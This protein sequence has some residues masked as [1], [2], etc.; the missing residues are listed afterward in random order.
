MPIQKSSFS[1]GGNSLSE[2]LFQWA[3]QRRAEQSAKRANKAYEMGLEKGGSDELEQEQPIL[4]FIGSDV[5]EAHNKGL[6]DAYIAGVDSDNVQRVNQIALE[7]ALPDCRK[8]L[9]SL[10]LFTLFPIS[11]PWKNLPTVVSSKG[12]PDRPQIPA[13]LFIIAAQSR[14]T[15]ITWR[16]CTI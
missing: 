7:N 8:K 2:S 11:F 3:G 12:F 16:F 14:K 5:V 1:T 6:R 9:P 13:R 4:G 15:G 10:F